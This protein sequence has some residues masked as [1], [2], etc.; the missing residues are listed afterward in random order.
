MFPLTLVV[1]AFRIYE[2]SQAERET[3]TSP[4]K[5][6]E[7]ERKKFQSIHTPM[8]R[9][10]SSVSLAGIAKLSLEVKI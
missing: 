8:L 9:V 7:Q 2:M 5:K 3:A 1:V 6:A 4:A 10:L